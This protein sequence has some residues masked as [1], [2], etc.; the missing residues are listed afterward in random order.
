MWYLL[1]NGVPRDKVISYFWLSLAIKNGIK[2]WRLKIFHNVLG[3]FLTKTLRAEIQKKV[4]GRNLRNPNET[5]SP[6]FRGH[7]LNSESDV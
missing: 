3:F 4:Q 1:A 2:K 6:E 7:E 5:D